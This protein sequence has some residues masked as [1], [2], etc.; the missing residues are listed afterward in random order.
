MQKTLCIKNVLYHLKKKNSP[1]DKETSDR[2]K[3][4]DLD[5][6]IVRKDKIEKMKSKRESPNI[7]AVIQWGRRFQ[8]PDLSTCWLNSCLQLLLSSLDHSDVDRHFQ[9]ELGLILSELA[10]LDPR[11]TIDPTDIK[12]LIIFERPCKL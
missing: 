12:N 8:N 4:L 9:S 10:N 2:H 7:D 3:D 5:K 11:R 1:K 6:R